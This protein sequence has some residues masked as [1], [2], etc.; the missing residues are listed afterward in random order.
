M[1]CL[2]DEQLVSLI[3]EPAVAEV[4]IAWSNHLD[5]C[6]ACQ[7]R[8][9]QLAG[10]TAWIPDW[11]G[12]SPSRLDVPNLERYRAM[13]LSESGDTFVGSIVT[14]P[15]EALGDNSLSAF[16][17]P[18]DRPE[19]CACFGPFYVISIIGRGGMGI[20][21]KAHDPSLK[22]NVAVKV[23]APQLATS[24]TARK[25]FLREARAAAQVVDDHVV[26]IHNVDEIQG[27][28][29]LVM[30]FIEGESLESKLRRTGPLA[31][32][33]VIRVAMETAKGLQAAH[34]AGDCAS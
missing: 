3:R 32:P 34:A 26:T 16:L 13:T 15:G 18:S 10:G 14:G 28:P 27:F 19:F 22:R 4:N 21:F 17:R 8:L 30:Q 24:E 29:Y 12:E 23:L 7:T 20:V 1:C 5:Q 33:E 11:D 6:A 31:I 9:E 25:R 2:S